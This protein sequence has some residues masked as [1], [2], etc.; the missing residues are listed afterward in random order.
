M[1][2]SSWQIRLTI[3]HRYLP[4]VHACFETCFDTE[5]IH[6]VSKEKRGPTRQTR[7]F[8]P[9]FEGKKMTAALELPMNGDKSRL[10]VFKQFW[11]L[12]SCLLIPI[13]IHAEEC[14]RVWII[15]IIFTLIIIITVL[16]NKPCYH[17]ER[18]DD[19]R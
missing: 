1:C 9:F 12:T 7:N 13:T 10:N 17:R 15:T 8:V 4:N 16:Y 6:Y 19:C 14:W 3:H 5:R 11:L 2:L 18:S